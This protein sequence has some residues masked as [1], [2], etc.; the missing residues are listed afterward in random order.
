[1]KTPK[2]DHLSFEIFSRPITQKDLWI[3]SVRGAQKRGIFGSQ[4]DIIPLFLW[5]LDPP[6]LGNR[7][8]LA[9]KEWRSWTTLRGRL[10][11]QIPPLFCV[12]VY[13]IRKLPFPARH[14][15]PTSGASARYSSCQQSKRKGRKSLCRVSIRESPSDSE[16][17]SP[18]AWAGSY[19][20]WHSVL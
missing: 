13:H 18:C 20:G 17:A 1:M 16:K 9:F 7:G 2:Q 4:A 12:H 3:D 11:W 19:L 14:S 6:V 10:F 8:V 5:V 15:A